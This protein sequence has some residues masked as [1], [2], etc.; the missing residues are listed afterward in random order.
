MRIGTCWGIYSYI[1]ILQYAQ[2]TR[3]WKTDGALIMVLVLHGLQNV[4]SVNRAKL[5]VFV[6]FYLINSKKKPHFYSVINISL[7]KSR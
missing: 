3:Y 6:R 1:T 4:F 2:H 5:S 7:V